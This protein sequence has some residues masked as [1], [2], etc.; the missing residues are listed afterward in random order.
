MNGGGYRLNINYTRLDD[1][2]PINPIEY[3]F[4]NED[5]KY[6]YSTETKTKA[7]KDASSTRNSNK[8]EEV[9]DS[10]LSISQ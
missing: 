4:Y 1:T 2:P 8:G 3:L 6:L 9:V 7:S 10:T 5:Q